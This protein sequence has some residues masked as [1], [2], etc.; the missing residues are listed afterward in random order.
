MS[1]YKKYNVDKN[2]QIGNFKGRL[3]LFPHEV[4]P[5]LDIYTRKLQEYNHEPERIKEL[6]ALFFTNNIVIKYSNQQEDDML[7]YWISMIHSGPEGFEQAM[8]YALID[9]PVFE[10]RLSKCSQSY[11]KD[12]I[13]DRTRRQE[14]PWEF[15]KRL[16]KKQQ[17]AERLRLRQEKQ[18]NNHKALKAQNIIKQ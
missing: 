18:E 14:K 15:P 7:N 13:A 6:A 17:K 3:Y 4:K 16:S 12:N 8:N 9:T 10:H 1:K 5:A 2:S 11:E